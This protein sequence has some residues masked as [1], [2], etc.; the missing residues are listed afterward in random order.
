MSVPTPDEVLKA[1]HPIIPAIYGALE[2]GVHSAREFFESRHAVIDPYHG[3]SHVR[4]EAKRYLDA[5][6][7]EVS[8]VDYQR[9][10]I[11]NNGLRLVFSHYVIWILKSNS[12]ELPAPGPSELRQQFYSQQMFAFMGSS[13]HE[14]PL[15]AL[16]VLWGVSATYQLGPLLLVCPEAGDSAKKS[17]KEY[18]KVSIPHPASI[19]EGPPSEPDDDLDMSLEKDK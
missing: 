5:L 7:H 14:D 17:V 19:V 16:V 18:W 15:L 1:L 10:E 8:S 6:N 11:A 4:W 9:E 12:G 3:P 13:Q 2:A